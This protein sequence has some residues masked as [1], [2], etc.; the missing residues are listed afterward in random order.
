[1]KKISKLW[2]EKYR[3]EVVDDII[4]KDEKLKETFNG[5]VKNKQFPNLLFGGVQGSGKST[6][7]HAL[8]RQ[9][10]IDSADVLKLNCSG[11]AGI[12]VLRTTVTGFSKTM[13]IGNFK[14]VQLEEYNGLS[15]QAQDSLRAVIEDSS[16]S[17]RFI[18]TTNYL[19]KVIPSIK[20]RFQEYNFQAPD[21]SEV[22]IYAMGI[23]IAEEIDFDDDLLEK[24]V[25]SA[26]PDI[27]KVVQLLQQ[28]S[29]NGV[30][31][32]PDNS[33]SV[34]GD[35][36]FQLLD[37]IEKNDFLSARTL[38]CN[39]IQSEEYDDLYQWLYQNIKH[40]PKFKTQEKEEQAIILIADHLYKHSLVAHPHI[41]LASLFIQLGQL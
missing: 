16:D 8:I 24:I 10:N 26:Y 14:V 20:S 3:P 38:V 22:L 33:A 23:L 41:L 35:Y 32:A 15:P 19:N 30:L 40:C 5:M 34:D 4:F 27:R 29:I 1:M 37:L 13:P 31:T 17:C 12:D 28:Y 2:V 21:S 18:I 6:L 9:C 11:S 25:N 36:K 7:S 39:N